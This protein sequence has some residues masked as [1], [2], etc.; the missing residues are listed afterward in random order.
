MRG[1]IANPD[2]VEGRDYVEQ[3]A[4]RYLNKYRGRGAWENGRKPAR[5]RDATRLGAL[6]QRRKAGVRKEER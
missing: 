4:I 3:G 1:F 5:R 6:L 2:S